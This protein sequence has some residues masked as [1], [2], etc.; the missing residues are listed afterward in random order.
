MHTVALRARIVLSAALLTS[1]LAARADY[2]FPIESPYESTVIGTPPE[3][4][5]PLPRKV[6]VEVRSIA[7][8]AERKVPNV[9]WAARNFRYSVA[10][11]RQPAPLLFLIASTG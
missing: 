11:Q 5:A 2:A 8:H 10:L 7:L 4:R 9:L 3:L 1:P 6:P